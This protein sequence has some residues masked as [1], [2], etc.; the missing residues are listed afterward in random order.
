MADC[1]EEVKKLVRET[2]KLDK[3]MISDHEI[4]L[5]VDDIEALRDQTINNADRLK[6]FEKRF[7]EKLQNQRELSLRDQ[8]TK[9]RNIIKKQKI[10]GRINNAELGGNAG[11]RLKA[12]LEGGGYDVLIQ[13][14]SL[15]EAQRTRAILSGN[16]E[17]GLEKEDLFKPLKDRSLEKDTMIAIYD[18]ENG[19]A[20]DQNTLGA[21]AAKHFIAVANAIRQGYEDAGHSIGKIAGWIMRQGHDAEKIAKD[22]PGWIADQLK[23]LD[24][25]KTFPT[26]A[27]MDDKIKILTKTAQD[28]IDGKWDRFEGPAEGAEDKLVTLAQMGVVGKEARSARKFHYKDGA[29]FYEYN[30]KWGKDSLL[31][32]T[33]KT[34]DKESRNI[35]LIRKFGTNPEATIATLVKSNALDADKK[36]IK[37][38]FYA[39]RGFSNDEVP[40]EL[41]AKTGVVARALQSMSKLSYTAVRAINDVNSAA[42][43][44]SSATGKNMLQVYA[45]MIPEFLSQVSSKSGMAQKDVAHKA[46]IFLSDHLH[47]MYRHGTGDTL[48]NAAGR[49]FGGLL[50]AQDTYFKMTGI[51]LQ[52]TTARTTVAKTLATTIAEDSHLS[53]N[54]L[55]KNLQATFKRFDIGEK[56]WEL[57]RLVKDEFHDGTKGITMEGID[58]VDKNSVDEILG[59]RRNISES[60]FKNEV[61]NKIASLYSNFGDLTVLGTQAR[62]QRIWSAGHPAGTVVGELAR[63]ALQFKGAAMTQ[64]DALLRIASPTGKFSSSSVINNVIPYLA[65]G[66]A[67]AYGI[68]AMIDFSKGKKIAD[69]TKAETW[70]HSFNRAGA[71][72][73]YQDLITGGVASPMDIRAKDYKGKIL[74]NL[75]GPTISNAANVSGALISGQ[76]SDA[77]NIA[78]Q[79]LPFANLKRNDQNVYDVLLLNH[80]NEFLNPGYN[81]RREIKLYKQRNR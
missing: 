39:V 18:S 55:D 64:T 35:A 12:E 56:E 3:K 8:L 53:F 15:Q 57:M 17:L 68:D 79:N 72:G 45:D 31:D 40:N 59:L 34:I 80:I 30:S 42:A 26:T 81:A 60:A 37:D 74:S 27:T 1:V 28:I 7:Q 73:I 51:R 5:I 24:H 70:T 32:S 10:Q 61:K 36:A 22:V 43:L 52:E 44:I 13:R 69:P 33:Y 76:F 49:F 38:A 54:Q 6:S 14:G 67:T 78:E 47:E 71:G 63:L 50:K 58:R 29:S 66:T 16:L 23:H 77:M 2:L 21:K 46:G 20:I 25:E 41:I 65:A 19:K 62:Y 75:A 11:A 9:A 4:E 48:P